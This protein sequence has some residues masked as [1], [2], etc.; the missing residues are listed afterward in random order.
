MAGLTDFEARLLEEVSR[1]NLW[2]H[3][4]TI[5]RW[6]RISGTQGERE[7]VA[8]LQER[9][10]EYGIRTTVYEF[11]ALLGWPE[12]AQI[13]LRSPVRRA[14]KSITHSFVPSTPPEG[15]EAEVAYLGAGEDADFERQAVAGKIVLLDGMASPMKVLRGQKH[16]VLAEIFVQPTRLHDMCVSPVWGT[17]TTKTAELLP[18]MPVASILGED[19]REIQ[20]LLQQGPV[21]LWMRTK[22]FW[23]WRTVPI[24]VG[25]IDAPSESE[26][27]VLLSGHHCSWY[28]GAMDNGSANATMLEVARVLAAHRQQLRRSFRVAFW[29]GHTQGRYAGSTWYF[30]H[31]WEDMHDNCVVH[32]NV[33]ST[34]AR[35]ANIYHSATMPETRDFALAAI[36]DAIGA[37]GHPARQSRAGDQSFW[38]CGVPSM[39]ME[40]SQVPLEMA[41]DLGGSGLF[42][43][44]G[45]ASAQPQGG[46][47]WWWHSADDTPDKIDPEV[48]VRDTR[49]Y[50]LACARVATAQLLPFRYAPS[51]QLLRESLERY[52]AGAGDRFDL[53]PA[54]ERARRVEAAAAEVDDLLDQLQRKPPAEVPFREINRD[55]MAMDRVLVTLNFSAVDPFEQDLAVPIP[56]VPQLEPAS[57]VGK[58]DAGAAETR[59][60]I[61][62]LTRNRN[63]VAFQLREALAAAER[64]AATMRR[65]L[66]A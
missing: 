30:D 60:L 61:T 19:G 27:F 37:E 44:A 3:T 58:M 1:E 57:R 22:T 55:L 25:Q 42:T 15:L 59:Y 13:E 41:A 35:G 6:E 48:H 34:G 39:W 10:N 38:G 9:L 51:A 23:D 62:E 8:Y 54:L 31:F 21:R 56:P 24:L 33:D 50:L 36:H 4:K 43:A 45:Q 53:G 5:A 46:M 49:V 40:L 32:V 17:P 7:A 52:Q 65:A 14:V 64:A 20:A 63:R 29:P 16:G 2:Q 26:Q 18:K 66:K 28:F 11:D 47:P 12:E